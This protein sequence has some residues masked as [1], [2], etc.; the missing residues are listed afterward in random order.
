[1]VKRKVSPVA[2]FSKHLQPVAERLS[3]SAD[4]I[5]TIDPFIS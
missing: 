5:P 1:M 3:V 4:L 2:R